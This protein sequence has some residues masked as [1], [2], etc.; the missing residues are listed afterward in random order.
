MM[1]KNATSAL[2]HH[3][4]PV[5]LTQTT[6]VTHLMCFS[7]QRKLTVSLN[8]YASAEKLTDCELK[9][10]KT[11]DEAKP[12]VANREKQNQNRYF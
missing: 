4:G 2:N 3:C 5:S 10:N 9:K 1:D 12:C 7:S 8:D 6:T 11:F